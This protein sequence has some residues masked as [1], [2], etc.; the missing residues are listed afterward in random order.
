MK[1]EG[2]GDRTGKKGRF[3]K[4]DPRKYPNKDNMGPLLGVTG[5]WAGGEAGLWEL[6]EQY[7]VCHD[8]H[9]DVMRPVLLVCK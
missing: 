9:A 5:G 4:D 1:E 7:K 2:F 6:R 3:I 8:E